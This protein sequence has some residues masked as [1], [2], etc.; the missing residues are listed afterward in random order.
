MS[1]ERRLR[2]LVGKVGLDGHDRGAKII[3]RAFRDAG[4]E[5]IYTGLHQTPEMVVQTAIQEDVDAVSLS[6]LSGAH[7]YLF[8]RV[9]ELLRERGA[10]DVAVFGGGIVP[11]ED[12]PGLKAAG[13]LEIFTPGTSTEAAVDWVKA[14]VRPRRL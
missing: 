4:F 5:V 13:V 6:I 11:D 14:N 1:E 10:H 2:L 9:I 12:I 8:P 3:A 7:N